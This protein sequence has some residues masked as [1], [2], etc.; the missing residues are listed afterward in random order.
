MTS[1]NFLVDP[2]I[3]QGWNGWS[4]SSWLM[5]GVTNHSAESVAQSLRE[6]GERKWGQSKPAVDTECVTEIPREGGTSSGL[7]GGGERKDIVWR[8][9]EGFVWSGEGQRVATRRREA[10]EKLR[11][12]RRG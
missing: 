2:E 5:V 9:E 3:S 11:G 7:D 4:V 10:W 6:G 1:L 12:G 8:F